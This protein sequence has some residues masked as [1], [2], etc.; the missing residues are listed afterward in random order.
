M[1]VASVYRAGMRVLADDGR[2]GTLVRRNRPYLQWLV[3]LDPQYREPGY[4]GDGDLTWWWESMFTRMT[5]GR[6]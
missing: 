6:P 2:T 3:E 4:G 1:A 5:N